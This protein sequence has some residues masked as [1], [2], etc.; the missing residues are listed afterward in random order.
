MGY[1]NMSETKK[2]KVSSE[3]SGLLSRANKTDAASFDTKDILR[4]STLQD[5]QPSRLG[6]P[7]ANIRPK[8]VLP[9]PLIVSR[10]KGDGDATVPDQIK[11]ENERR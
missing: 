10:L 9:E 4:D 11:E 7:A 1:Q 5:D 2:E 3:S 8:I 6:S